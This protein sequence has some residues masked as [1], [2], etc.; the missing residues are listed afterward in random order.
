MTTIISISAIAIL[1][2]IIIVIAFSSS[3][4]CIIRKRQDTKLRMWCIEQAVQTDL[5]GGI[6]SDTG[7]KYASEWNFVSLAEKYYLF[8]TEH[9]T[10]LSDED[11]E[12]IFPEKYKKKDN[13]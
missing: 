13:P 6:D 5:A 10:Y 7:T 1:L 12:A 4:L 2:L 9:I 3:I 8:L 11:K